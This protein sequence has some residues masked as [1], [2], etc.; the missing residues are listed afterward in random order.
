MRLPLCRATSS[1]AA[2]P[3]AEEESKADKAAKVVLQ[4]QALYSRHTVVANVGVVICFPALNRKE[5]ALALS[6][7]LLTLLSIFS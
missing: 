2:A 3:A 1:G 4:Y 6:K 7:H 5:K